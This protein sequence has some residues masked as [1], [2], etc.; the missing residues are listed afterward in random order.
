MRLLTAVPGSEKRPAPTI[1]PSSA[2]SFLQRVARLAA[3]LGIANEGGARAV[4]D[5]AALSMGETV[6]T[7]MTL[8]HVL[9]MVE[10]AVG[11]QDTPASAPAVAPASA[12]TVEAEELAT[13]VQKS[14]AD[15]KKRQR[16]QHSGASPSSSSQSPSNFPSPPSRAQHQPTLF[17]VAGSGSKL[18]MR[19]RE[20]ESYAA[21]QAE[22]KAVSLEQMQQDVALEVVRFPSEIRPRPPPPKPV[23]DCVGCGKSFG[24]AVDLASHRLWKHPAQSRDVRAM[25]ARTFRG[26]LSAPLCVGADG[27]V[28]MIILVNGKSR[29]QLVREAEADERAAD[30][31]KVEREA[32]A[33]RRVRRE[34]LLREAEQE[35]GEQRRGSAHR[36]SYTFKEKVPC[37]PSLPYALDPHA[38]SCCPAPVC[39]C[40]SCVTGVTL[41]DWPR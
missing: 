15:G 27:V 13:P 21:R 35:L 33:A 1:M 29:E 36:A 4:L 22:G 41:N 17:S 28:S 18:L 16:T 2:M 31:A 24:R 9:A 34:M 19:K 3:E 5:A 25:P 12:A 7:G 8:P 23:F 26:S 38:P 14:T 30:A 40:S 39:S 11:L 10:A 20:R 6:S 37:S 32:E